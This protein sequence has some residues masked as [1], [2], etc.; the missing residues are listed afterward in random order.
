MGNIASAMTYVENNCKSTICGS[1]MEQQRL[2]DAL[3]SGK[4]KIEKFPRSCRSK[5]RLGS[6]TYYYQ[7]YRNY[8]LYLRKSNINLRFT[9]PNLGSRNYEGIN[10]ASS[11]KIW[12]LTQSFH[13]DLLI[14]TT[15]L[16]DL[17][18]DYWK[19]GVN[20]WKKEVENVYAR[21]RCL[22]NV[23]STNPCEHLK[24]EDRNILS[25]GEVI[26]TAFQK[27]LETLRRTFE[28]VLE[29]KTE[30]FF[31][32]NVAKYCNGGWNHAVSGY[33]WVIGL[34]R[35]RL[36]T[37]L[38]R[39]LK[40]FC[41]SLSA[42]DYIDFSSVKLSCDDGNIND[43]IHFVFNKIKGTRCNQRSLD[44]GMGSILNLVVRTLG[45]SCGLKP[46]PI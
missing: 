14:F 26:L 4:E 37:E 2:K 20:E 18:V 1:K 44:T 3:C 9:F 33:E 19:S 30:L 31:K 39:I 23:S 35:R 28:K 25:F 36:L 46:L 43:G 24:L 21:D 42:C 32:A 22:L 12:R 17:R 5:E 41:S 11:T 40:E 45:G 27:N 29:T 6:A 38:N 8:M 10:S 13:P 16:H 7:H 34:Y 15:G